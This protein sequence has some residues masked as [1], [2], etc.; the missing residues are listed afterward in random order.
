V[1]I[2]IIN[3]KKNNPKEKSKNYGGTNRDKIVRVKDRKRVDPEYSQDSQ[4]A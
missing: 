2:S 3:T 1:K 4:G